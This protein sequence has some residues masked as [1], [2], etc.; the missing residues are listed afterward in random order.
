M[1]AI[2]FS[3]EYHDVTDEMIDAILN[4]R[5]SFLYFEGNPWIKKNTTDHF[6]VTEGSFDG[7]EV[8]EIV[9]LFLLKQL[10]ELR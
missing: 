10:N 5:K 4:S 1:S 9:G 3:K 2:N 8:C 6:D 7:S